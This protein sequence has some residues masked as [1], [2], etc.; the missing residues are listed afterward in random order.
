MFKYSFRSHMKCMVSIII[1]RM[2]CITTPMGQPVK[3][4]E[5]VTP[6]PS[7][8][9]GVSN[10]GP[11]RINSRGHAFTLGLPCE[12]CSWGKAPVNLLKEN[13]LY[14]IIEIRIINIL[15]NKFEIQEQ[16]KTMN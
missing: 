9:S 1:T 12:G 15:Y 6:N 7:S 8:N 11:L 2:I 13:D 16:L 5:G 14:Y 4:W 10:Q 3:A